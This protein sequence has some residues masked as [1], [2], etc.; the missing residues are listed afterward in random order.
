VIERMIAV[1]S[2]QAERFSAVLGSRGV[3]ASQLTT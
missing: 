2:D 1:L 3:E